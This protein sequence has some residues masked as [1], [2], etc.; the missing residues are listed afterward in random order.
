MTD[1]LRGRPADE[2]A[3]PGRGSAPAPVPQGER[4]LGPGDRIPN[5]MLPDPRGELRLFYQAIAGWP[6]VLLLAA[7]TAM[8]DQWDEIKGFAAAAPALHAAGAKLMIVSNDGIDSLA[9]VAKI[10]PEHAHWLA[11]IKGVVNLGLRQGALFA[12]TG[13]VCFV[14]DANQRIV[15]LRGAEPGHAEWALAMLNARSSES[16][17]QLSTVAPVLLLPAALDGEDC[18]VLLKQISDANTTSGSAGIADKALAERIGK[19][20]LRRIGPEVE[21]AFSFDDFVVESLALRWDDSA[22]AADRRVE[23]DDPA[24]QGRSFSLILDL[25]GEAYRGGDIQFPEYGP[26][27]YRPGSG[28]ALV[29]AGTLLRELR[30]VSTGRRSLLVATLR[31][32]VS[33]PTAKA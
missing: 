23:V 10:I 9:M 20:L 4:L 1:E 13:A 19:T 28:G 6:T 15:G 16:P 32:P 29:F 17:Q 3:P 5:F 2:K 11:D 33:T 30:S 21:K 22:A 27:S 25:A 14:L 18:A 12:F 8:Q 31:R 24:V 7:N 26:H